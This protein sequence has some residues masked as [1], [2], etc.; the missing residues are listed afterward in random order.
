MQFLRKQFPAIVFLLPLGALAQAP[1]GLT[2]RAATKSRVDLTW[3]GTAASY[4][5]QRRALGGSYATISTVSATTASDTTV[6]PYT[7]YQYQIVAAS[8]STTPS[9]QVTAGPP[10]SGFS[11]A[12]TGPGLAGSQLASNYGFDI[13]LVLDANGD[14]AIAFLFDDPNVDSDHTDTQLLFRSWNRATYQWNNAV[15]VGR[16]GDA[17]STFHQSTSLGYDASTNTFAVASETNQ[18]E[19]ILVWVSTDGGATF[20]SKATIKPDNGS[21]EPSLALRGGNIYLA[22]YEPFTGIKYVTGALSAASTTWTTKTAPVPNGTTLGSWPSLAVDSSG[23]PAV[24][25]WGGSTTDSYNQILL[26]W[27]PAGTTAP[28]QVMDS[29]N[30]QSDEASVKLAFSGTNPRVAVYVQRK[31]ADFGVGL[32]FARSDNGGTTWTTPVVIPPDGDSS[33]DYPF[34]LALSSTGAGAIAYGQNGGT[35]TSVCGN[36]KLSRSSD[37]NTWKTCAADDLSVTQLFNPYP[38]SIALLYGGNDKLYMFWQETYDSAVGTGILMWREPPAGQSNAPALDSGSLHNGATDQPNVVAGSWAQVKGQNLAGVTRI[39]KE[40]DFTNVPNLPTAL[41]GV[42]VKVNNLP[43]A[44]YYISPGQINFQVP[45]A[46]SGTANVQVIRDG[47]ASNT[48]SGPA[49]ANAPGL[50]SYA[51]GGKTYP[52]AVFANS[53]DI[54]GDPAAAG[55]GVRKAKAGDNISLFATGIQATPGGVVVDAPAGV[56]GVTATVGTATATVSFA[57]LV[58]VGEFQV[59]IVVPNLTAGEYPVV[60]RYNG[61]SSQSGII[62]P[63]Q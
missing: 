10:P 60:I 16:V 13:S 44:V 4:N 6:D 48:I 20:T 18:G 23:A 49:V 51:V 21:S 55:A 37:L 17:T 33:T 27:R 62:I 30:Q 47:I 52:A 3:T 50:F 11:V 25:Y 35:G 9:N 2:V 40:E 57:G 45:T 59:N 28:V 26:F 56:S 61:L 15:V 54:V 43:A 58:A 8:G 19:S 39:W 24:A 36:P 53:V 29:Q 7:T 5:V 31:D 42:Q 63:V 14:P 46:V 1:T 34:D 38:S 12:A 22:Y 32:H 41:S